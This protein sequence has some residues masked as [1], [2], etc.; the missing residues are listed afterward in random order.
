[1]PTTWEMSSVSAFLRHREG[2]EMV[3]SESL[4]PPFAVNSGDAAHAGS[5]TVPSTWQRSLTEAIRDPE[6]LIE[7]LQ[8]SR[9]LLPAGLAAAADFPL[10]VPLSYLHRMRPG[11]PGDPLLRQVL[12]I[13]SELADVSGFARDAVGDAAARRAPGLLHKYQGRALLIAAR[14]CAINCR[15]CFRRHYPYADEPAALDDWQPALDELHADP[16]I[17][18]II[19]SGGDPL[20]LSNQRLSRLIE[21]LEDVPHLRRLR[22][23][24][25]LPIVLPD[26][27]EPALIERLRS[28]RLACLMVVHANH[29]REIAGDCIDAL[30]QLV[31]RGI[32][33]LN[34]SVLLRRINDDADVLAELSERLID[35]GVI[36]YYLH[37]LDRV[38]GV[39]HFEVA[40]TRGRELVAEL[41]RR[42]PG[43]AVPRYVREVEGADGKVPLE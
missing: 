34:Q 36:P 25:R 1:M 43:Y 29:P 40:E 12:P 35:L 39:A 32:P 6:Q 23:H 31:A 26:R 18:E 22:I 5:R 21:R 9:D 11:D 41:R 24:S 13:A 38:Q 10:V 37:Q 28:S 8:L 4:A 14:Q 33:T 7:R 19:L 20:L 2:P 17:R 3:N 16:S 42:L 30:R 27:V 15:Y